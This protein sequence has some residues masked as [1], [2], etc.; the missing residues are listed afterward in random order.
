M[1]VSH[2]NGRRRPA[3]HRWL[4]LAAGLVPLAAVQAA[5]DATP[6]LFGFTTPEAATQ[7]ALE[8]RF[9][10][11]LNPADLRGWMQKLSSAP[12][13]VGSPH[14]K[15]NAEYVRDLFRQWGWQAQIE[16]FEVL[17]PT[18]KQHSLELVAPS[19]FTASLTEPPVAGDATSNSPGIMPPYNV[20]GAD[21]D[22]TGELVYANYGMP[23]DYQDLA[24]RGI[25]V[26]G[27]IVITRYGGGWR[28][29]KPKLAQEHGAI[30]CIIYS[31]PREDGYAQGDVYP[32]GGWRPPEGVQRGSV[33]DITLYSGDPLT[34]G[35]GATHD[36]K[37]LAIADAKTILKIPVMPISYADAQPLLAALGGP[38][39][40]PRWR[41]ALPIT[42]H[43]GPGPAQVHLAISSDW[44]LKPLYDVIAKIPGRESRNEWVV[45]GNHRDGWVFGAWDPLSGHV[46][47][48]AEAQA[49]GAL[50][51]SGWRP[52]RTLVYAS[53]DGEEPGLLGS[54]E[55]AETHAAELATK[56]VLY[57]NS[58]TNARGFLS[59]GGSHALQHLVNEV[60]SAV[61]DP[62][63]GVSTQ[64]RLRARMLAEG[65][66]RGSSEDEDADEARREARLAA[67][68]GDL[69]IRALGSGSDYT[70]FLQHLGLTALN[71]EYHGEDDQGG[72]Y[73]SAYDSFDHYVRF[74]DPSFAYGVAEAE[75]VG[76][77]VLRVAD[78]DVL[79]LEFASFADTIGAYAE[80]LRHAVDERRKKSA[81]LAKL[82]EQ[83]DFG[84][85]TD[86]TR[87]VAPPVREA[88]VPALDFAPLDGVVT[89]LKASARA[90]DAA[91]AQLLAG[92]VKLDATQR[93]R[94]NAL[95]QGMEQRL[96]DPKGLPGREWYRHFLYA[97][98]M[99]TGYGVKTLPGVREAIDG[100]RWDEAAAY[101]PI[102][103]AVL[104]RYCDA[105]D[106]ATALLKGG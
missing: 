52:Q 67:A 24:R 99:L 12:N 71:I 102:T 38:V 92:T 2:G 37:R 93:A 48:L 5:G 83:N 62:E 100:N 73:H 65:Y 34:P 25:D 35:V 74:G 85:S 16:V 104:A 13:Q 10:G 9:D 80:E 47:M 87:P 15:A 59:V 66:E 79:P 72:V 97:P 60:A 75:T 27:K 64:A 81:E 98:G 26:K 6:G 91:Y 95:L 3:A 54:T 76:H 55:W 68:G 8:Q 56:A 70:P 36:A 42:Y 32:K 57:L 86:P 45:R 49:I 69:P 90:Y 96:T 33:L 23:K 101:I 4:A 30:G 51:K 63:T 20:Y 14:D 105:I 46:A 21:G 39:A 44:S 103:A 41:G 18:L 19:H 53:W 11:A 106:S 61:K 31:D 43:V 89:R 28:G 94:L 7:R 17:Y 78:A 50:V 88:P 22:V 1:Q 29:L 58:D 84:L 82:L 40:P 77:V